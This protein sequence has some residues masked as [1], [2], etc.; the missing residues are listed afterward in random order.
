MHK[1]NIINVLNNLKSPSRLS[2]DFISLKIEEVL[3]RN[4]LSARFLLLYLTN[5]C[6]K[7][8]PFVLHIY[9]WLSFKVKQPYL[10]F[11][12]SSLLEC[13][14][15]EEIGFLLQMSPLSWSGNLLKMKIIQIPFILSSRMRFLEFQMFKIFLFGIEKNILSWIDFH[16]LVRGRYVILL[17]KRTSGMIVGVELNKMILKKPAVLT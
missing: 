2:N 9:S 12:V 3:W 17:G 6:F 14:H 7:T 15:A 5:V 8:I 1:T 16:M 11:L 13:Y 4:T 10:L